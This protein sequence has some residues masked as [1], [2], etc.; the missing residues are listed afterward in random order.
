M[1]LQQYEKK[2]MYF[3]SIELGTSKK[4]MHL[5]ELNPQPAASFLHK[6]NVFAWNRTG[7]RQLT[8]ERIVVLAQNR[9][10]DLLKRASISGN[11]GFRVQSRELPAATDALV[12]SQS[13]HSRVVQSTRAKNAS[14]LQEARG[15]RPPHIKLRCRTGRLAT[16]Q[17][18][19][20][21]TGAYMR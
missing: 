15:R 20:N 7:D 17:D 19:P 6:R 8:P 18:N 11:G 12:G 5:K 14:E 4:E 9:T 10:R 3:Y 2:R 13:W 1:N 21:P 16:C